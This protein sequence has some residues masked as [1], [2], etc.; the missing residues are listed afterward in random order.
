MPNLD[1]S[2]KEILQTLEKDGVV[3]LQNFLSAEA[4]SSLQATMS[5]RLAHGCWNTPFGYT[6]EDNFRFMVEDVLTMDEHFQLA[7]LDPRISDVLKSYLGDHYC[8]VEA[9]A[10][11]SLPCEKDF[12]GWHNDAWYDHSLA[13]VPRQLKLGIYL[14]DVKSG[15]FT[16]IRATHGETRHKL[17]PSD[18]A[19]TEKDRI[20]TV[21]GKAGTAI[22]FDTSG[23]HRQSFPILEQRDAVFFCYND[24]KVP[25]QK[26]DV[27]YYRY[28]PLHLNAAFLGSLNS[29]QMRVLGFGNRSLYRPAFVRAPR[30][31]K[32]SNFLTASNKAWIIFERFYT[33]V[34]AR[35]KKTFSASA[36]RN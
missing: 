15:A 36:V 4:I 35:I 26:E 11:R 23:I 19:E 27:D 12:H 25:L 28:H 7:A 16:Y 31:Q 6:N 30:N 34:H 14:T 33:R 17:V 32:I 3:V 10:W 29:E 24:P 9:K 8:L 5:S 13:N 22:L 21:I 20:L 1:L 18:V 2:Q